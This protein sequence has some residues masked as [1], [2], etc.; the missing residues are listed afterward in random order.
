M[1]SF[2][3][4]LVAVAAV[5]SSISA[6][7]GSEPAQKAALDVSSILGQIDFSTVIVGILAAGG[8]L[9]GPRIAKM[10]VRFILGLF[11]R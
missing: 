8:V 1:F 7:A 2:K 10:A 11:G 9:M 6:F 4:C 3:K 5:G